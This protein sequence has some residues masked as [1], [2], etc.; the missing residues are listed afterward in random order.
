MANYIMQNDFYIFSWRRPFLED[1]QKFIELD[2]AGAP[3]SALIIVPN[4]RPWRYFQNIYAKQGKASALPKMISFPELAPLWNLHLGQ[5]EKFVANSLDVV[6]LL[7]KIINSGAIEDSRLTKRFANMS[8]EKFMPWGLRLADLLDEMQT[9]GIEPRDINYAESE[10]S[11]PAADLLGAL[12]RINQK[13][14]AELT[15][16]NWTTVGYANFT[17][18]QNAQNIPP[19]FVPK[20]DRPVYIAGF[21]ALNG[22]QKKLFKALWNAGAKVCLHTDPAIMNADKSDPYCREHRLWLQNWHARAVMVGKEDN[23]R[24]PPETSFW[25]GYDIHSQIE[26][27]AENMAGIRDDQSVAVI[28]TNPDILMPVLHHLPHKDVNI[29][30]GYPLDR[31]PLINFFETILT[32]V[33]SR[34]DDGRYYWKDLR[35]VLR[36]PYLKMLETQNGVS[37]REPLLV[38]D[39]SITSGNKFV[40][41]QD[42]IVQTLFKIDPEQQELLAR[43]FSICLDKFCQVTDT[44][45]LAEALDGLRALLLEN[46]AKVWERFPLDA[47]ALNTL[48]GEIIPTLRYNELAQDKL[49]FPVLH[50]LFTE[51]LSKTRIPFEADPLTGIQILGLLETRLLQFD[52]IF[53]L[54]ATEDVLPGQ[55]ANDPLISDSLRGLLGLNDARTREAA[56]AHNLFHL[57]AGSKE[58]RFFWQEGISQ[59]VL[60]DSKKTRSRFVEE[61]IWKEEQKKGKILENNQPPLHVAVASLSVKAKQQPVLEITPKIRAKLYK[62]L[63]KPINPSDLDVYYKCPLRFAR[64]KLLKL[65]APADV[66]EGDDP[67]L[68]GIFI[69]RVLQELLAPDMNQPI[70][71][72]DISRKV[73]MDVFN[74]EIKNMRMAEKLPVDSLLMLKLSGPVRIMT[75]LKK[76]KEL[77][78]LAIEK[79]FKEKIAIVNKPV[80][81]KG[82]IDRIDARKSKKVI[83]DYKIGHVPEIDEKFWRQ[84]SFFTKITDYCSQNSV[85]NEEGEELFL[86]LRTKLESL[87]L[88]AYVYLLNKASPGEVGNAVYVELK[89]KGAEKALFKEKA[90]CEEIAQN[91]DYCGLIV[92][93]VIRHLQTSFVFNGLEGSC[94][95][96]EY[97]DLCSL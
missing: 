40:D 84:H 51:L 77:T 61:L 27:L 20:P 19:L 68:V 95:W 94:E 23:D 76:I 83:V 18:M 12:G 82:K 36:Q 29:S 44:R 22:V 54:D 48:A 75:Y 57:Y 49:S 4:K 10:V 59:S 58:A 64:E 78:I 89:D 30:M 66:N 53:V 43:A 81:L 72:L 91:I 3:G 8:L 86:E 15:D 13:F 21:Y 67:L 46:G 97:S 52:T 25:A 41:L 73:V 85:M 38:M 45:T 60:F 71:E 17:A 92:S 5:G 90:S 16:R 7:S 63:Q 69:H 6:A 50:G 34:Q 42:I 55:S 2:T 35:A 65:S 70:V 56:V 33:E 80:W 26:M 39:E 96:C 14:I 62:F 1:L 28:C 9:E 11:P 24:P 37:L 79:T 93:F 88:P 32:A 31:S 47:E 87:Q 74:R